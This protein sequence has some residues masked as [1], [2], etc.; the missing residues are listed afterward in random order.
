M[1]DDQKTTDELVQSLAGLL[2]DKGKVSLSVPTLSWNGSASLVQMLISTNKDGKADVIHL[3]DIDLLPPIK[4]D[5]FFAELNFQRDTLSHLGVP[6]ILWLSNACLPELVSKAPDFWSRRHA[7]YKFDSVS[8]DKLLA[9][10]FD[11]ADYDP[12]TSTVGG[13]VSEALS[14][15]LKAERELQACLQ[16][17]HE[18]SLGK[19]DRLI[20]II[21]KELS[22]LREACRKGKQ[23]EVALWLWNLS[24]SDSELRRMA[25]REDRESGRIYEMLYTERNEVLLYLSEHVVGVL[26]RYGNSLED[27]IRKRQ[28]LSLVKFYI[29]AAIGKFQRMAR[30]ARRG[31][32]QFGQLI[33]AGLD[34]S[35]ERDRGDTQLLSTIAN[36]LEAWLCGESRVLPPVFSKDE[37]LLLRSL[38]LGSDDAKHNVGNRRELKEK[39][40]DLQKKVRLYLGVV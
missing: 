19:A 35:A 17:E 6:L 7:V 12:S 40:T 5:R 26:E 11:P 4:R 37:G 18:F 2:A 1:C 34:V 30:V 38:Y 31:D 24:R 10:I 25:I 32:V 29:D 3:R 13:V 22:V 20:S 16:H 33:E 36:Q 27:K 14:E 15:I 23:M 9:Q 39:I 28:L 8:V 21:R